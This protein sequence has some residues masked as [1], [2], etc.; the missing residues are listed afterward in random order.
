MEGSLKEQIRYSLGVFS[1]CIIN[2]KK[3]LINNYNIKYESEEDLNEMISNT[4][5]NTR[6]GIV[7]G[8][9]KSEILFSDMDVVAYAIVERL[10]QCLV[11]YKAN[12]DKDKIKEIV[13]DK[14]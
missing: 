4:F 12:V 3:N 11:F 7:H 6:N 10:V 14:F 1:D 13:D 9:M 8:N 5:K 2:V